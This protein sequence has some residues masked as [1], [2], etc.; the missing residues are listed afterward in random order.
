MKQILN[1]IILLSFCLCC[2]PAF[3][4]DV[5]AKG[6]SIKKVGDV[7]HISFDIND[8]DIHPNNKTVFS[9][10][11]SGNGHTLDLHKLTIYGR[12]KYISDQ[13][14]GKP[15]DTELH[16]IKKGNSSN[17]TYTETVQWQ[18]WMQKVDLKLSKIEEGCGSQRPLQSEVLAKDKL[19]FY[20]VSPLFDDRALEYELTELERYD[21]ENPFLHPAEDYHKRYEILLKDRDKGTSII[22][23]KVGSHVIDMDMGDNKAVLESVIKALE[24]ISS[25]PNAS[26]KK[27]I[28][29]GYASPEG[30]L[31]FNTELAQRRAE[32]VVSFLNS[33]IRSAD[34]SV[35]ELYNGREDWDGLKE[36]VGNSMMQNKDEVIRVIDSYTIEQEERKAH[37]KKLNG[38]STYRYML[39]NFYP[40]LR[41]A[42]YVQVYYDI[43][44][45]ATIPTAITDESGRTTWIDPDSPQNIG[46]TQI[47][48]AIELIKAA[49]YE[50]ALA[51]LEKTPERKEIYNLKGVCQMML[52]DYD[53][54][55]IM[56][57]KAI[58][59]GDDK[60]V[61]NLREL[62]I[63]GSIEK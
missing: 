28:V 31:K 48:R 42:G 37:L 18:D 49:K 27:I 30:S 52:G 55:R 62:D 13:R 21:L 57:K 40:P 2:F 19:L 46:V 5:P 61:D 29:A 26:L 51:L 12:R 53:N 16:I 43:D 59:H 35:Y 32:S 15:D 1:Y 8:T 24:L 25:D 23:F 33:E 7:V 10:V 20:E 4:S 45:R 58:E 39:E 50:E 11:L 54:A 63:V 60:A 3:G 22:H 6:A 9:P 36:L 56:F 17:I 38:G 47:N 44:R 41:N 14:G 34:N